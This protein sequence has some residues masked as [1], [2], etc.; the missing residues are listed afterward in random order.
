MSDSSASEIQVPGETVCHTA[1]FAGLRLI[2]CGG[3]FDYAT[4]DYLS[5]TVV[6]A[7]LV[8]SRPA[9]HRA[10][11]PADRHKAAIG[12]TSISRR[13]GRQAAA[14]AKWPVAR[15]SR[16]KSGHLLNVRGTS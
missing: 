6:L 3:A 1:H 8:A 10:S 12:P 15:R 7:F 16:P 4:S 11:R 9:G 14:G 13:R 5:S 2:T